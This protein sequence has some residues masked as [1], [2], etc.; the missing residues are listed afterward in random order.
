MLPKI[1][2]MIEMAGLQFGA[3]DRDFGKRGFREDLFRD[4]ID[5]NVR[6]RPARDRGL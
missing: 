2:G 1:A 6:V 4:I 3:G 5:R